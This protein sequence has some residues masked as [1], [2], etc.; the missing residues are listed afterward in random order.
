[1]KKAWNKA[2]TLISKETGNRVCAVFSMAVI[3][4]FVSSA[5]HASGQAEDSTD[6]SKGL[7]AERLDMPAERLQRI[8]RAL[9]G[10]VDRNEVAGVVAM[11]GRYGKI[12]YRGAFGMAD[13]EAGRPIQTDTIFLITQMTKPVVS[14]AA[15]MLY[16]EGHFRLVDQ[17]SKF[18]P[19]FKDMQV[20]VP[21]GDSYS[22]VPAE[23]R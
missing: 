19:E 4:V 15:M 12:A 7:K 3:L 17:V 9:Q 22:L 2:K 10:Y 20:L 18:I 21:E 5:I 16:E 13:I 8:D 6:P 11:I 14:V 23:N 1:M